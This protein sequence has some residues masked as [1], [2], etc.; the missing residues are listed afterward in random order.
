MRKFLSLLLTLALVLAM[1]FGAAMA[2][3]M[4]PGTYTGEATGNNGP[5]KVAVT[6]DAQ[7]ILSVEVVEH[8]ETAGICDT[9]IATIPGAIVEAQSVAVDTISGATNTS[10][11]IIAAV[12][13]ALTQAGANLEDFSKKEEKEFVLSEDTKDLSADVIIVGAGGAGLA[14]ATTVQQAG[15][16][17]I[18]VEKMAMIGGNTA[19]SGSTLNAA[20]P[21][22]QQKVELTADI[23][24]VY[25]AVNAEPVSEEH[26]AL[27]Q[28]VKEQLKAY[29]ASG[30]TY[31]F[32]SP[33]LHALNTFDAG[34]RVGD[35]ALIENMCNN[36][37][38]ARTWLSELGCEWTE[39]VYLTIGGLWPRSMNA[40]EGPSGIIN[41][42]KKNVPDD[43]IMLNTKATELIVEDGKVTGVKA[44]D[45]VSGQQY[46]LHGN[47][48]L[49]TGGYGANA[50]L[51]AKLHNIPELMTSNASSSTGDGMLMAQ[52]IG[53]ALTGM[54]KIQ[55]HPHGNPK[56]GALQ[57]H[58]AG[59]VTNSIY[60]NK[61][62]HRFTEETG[63]RD[64]ISNDTLQ[65]TDHIMFSI[66]DARTASDNSDNAVEMGNAYKA[67]TLED[68]AKQAGIDPD[69]LVAEVARYNELVESG[70]DTDFG[71]KAV[72]LK[73]EE[74]PF[75][76]VPL[77]PTIHHTMG[78]VKIDTDARV[79][80]EAGE[81]IDGLY[82]AGEVTGGIHGGNRIG[83]NAITDIIVY[84]RIAG[85][86]ALAD[87]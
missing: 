55:I 71:K 69:G 2:E 63:R 25:D 49:A 78:G 10:N 79:Y 76:C 66:Y 15:G 6:V 64:T 48:I 65:Q 74:A 13:D 53:A 75:Y 67:D 16:S 44:Y 1:P 52:E 21:E 37:L 40:K 73:I 38:A 33:E 39:K 31:I 46:A 62:G 58:F 85:E 86:N 45:E 70:K 47:V 87:K 24:E 77:S 28:K 82:A 51:V 17:Y 18:V 9:P 41:A 61:E 43:A 57:S 80:N 19:R 27:Q 20:D 56:T 84:G 30:A 22:R 7:S 35:L 59:S 4:T 83:G 29:V 72:E 11:A 36:A 14:A 23:Q 34:D 81:I 3:G 68:L 12:T 50:A 54:D 26:A 42:L 60:V 32:D 5:V 8:G